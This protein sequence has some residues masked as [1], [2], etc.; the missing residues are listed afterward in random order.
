MGG[1]IAKLAKHEPVLEGSA[2][3]RKRS[4]RDVCARQERTFEAQS[5]RL[6]QTEDTNLILY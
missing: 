6:V 2:E 5:Y 4:T 3:G 1:L